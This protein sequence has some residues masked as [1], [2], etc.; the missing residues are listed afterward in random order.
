ML[1]SVRYIEFSGQGST[2]TSIW[3]QGD[4]NDV[5]YWWRLYTTLT[6][7]ITSVD[8]WWNMNESINCV[9][10]IIGM[11]FAKWLHDICDRT[12]RIDGNYVKW[13]ITFNEMLE[14]S[15]AHQLIGTVPT[16]AI[17]AFRA[18]WPLAE[19]HLI[20]F[21]GWP[22]SRLYALTIHSSTSYL[23]DR[24]IGWP[25]ALTAMGKRI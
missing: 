20:T 1:I 24:T 7:S 8:W 23:R 3:I 16:A 14:I 11:T 9:R 19:W 25:P 5:S 2:F 12:V 15:R 4:H 21:P 17:V 13:L 6:K 10:S 18:S 22:T